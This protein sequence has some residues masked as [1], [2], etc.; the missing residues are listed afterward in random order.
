VAAGTRPA[1][2]GSACYL[3]AS[4]FWGLN[5]PLTAVLL[6]T[7]DAFWLTL[8]RYAIAASLLGALVAAML[9]A[10]AL[11]SPIPVRRVAVLGLCVAGFLV[12]FTVGLRLVHPV[13]AA[14]VIAG[15]PVYV[16]VV[17]RAMTRAPFAPGFWSATALTV[18]GAGIAIWGAG[19]ATGSLASGGVADGWVT[20][21][22]E[23]LLVASIG[24]WTV[25]SILAQR[26]FE[27]EVPQLRR[28]WLSS[29][30]A[31][32]WLAAFWLAARA[33]GWA[34]APNLRPDAVSL[35]YLVATATLSTALS[36]V[37]WN[38]GVARLG[39]AVGGMW[40]NTVP[41]FAVLTSLLFFG[42]VPTG[43]QV[44]GGAVVLAG[45]LTMQRHVIVAAWRV[46][47][48]S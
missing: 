1:L 44:L 27:T 30:G 41:V 17:S 37:A 16:A 13:T 23:A 45:V 9:G 6:K 47:S 10:R 19:G 5:I 43:A 24:S 18:I 22:G 3:L 33:L 42:V 38:V 31:L 12:C 34:G 26:W 32:P 28:T 8:S 11:R 4:V 36:T 15:S 29:A 25:Y 14:A 21:G 2:V 46:R 35:A 40:Q 48:A 7:F 39:I 20:T